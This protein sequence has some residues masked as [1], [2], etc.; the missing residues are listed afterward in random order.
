MNNKTN[1][2]DKII[3]KT[4]ENSQELALFQEKFSVYSEITPAVVNDVLKR[5]FEE[6]KELAQQELTSATYD[7]FFVEECIEKAQ[8][9]SALH[10]ILQE[11]FEEEDKEKES[12]KKKIVELSF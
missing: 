1:I 2:I 11:I 12:L 7:K 10:K 6:N 5:T 9:A 8:Q 3:T 4:G